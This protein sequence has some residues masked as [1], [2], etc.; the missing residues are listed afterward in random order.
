MGSHNDKVKSAVTAFLVKALPPAM[1][2]V[3]GVLVGIFL[4]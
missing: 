4:F 2:F 3:A 1:N